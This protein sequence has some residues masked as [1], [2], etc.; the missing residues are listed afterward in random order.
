[1][2][3]LFK[4][5]VSCQTTNSWVLDEASTYNIELVNLK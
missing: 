4:I 3:S 5:E 1:M 2:S